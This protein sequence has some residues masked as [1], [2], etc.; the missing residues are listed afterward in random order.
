L[1]RHRRSGV[2]TESQ[3]HERCAACLQSSRERQVELEAVSDTRRA[4][5]L[6][7]VSAVVIEVEQVDVEDARECAIWSYNER[8]ASEAARL[9]D[10]RCQHEAT[11]DS[12][13]EFLDRITVNFLRYD[14]TSYD[15]V[16][17][18]LFRLVGRRQAH[19]LLYE[20]VLGVIAADY[21]ALAAECLR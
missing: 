20:R 10:P 13:P 19:E 12:D 5:G 21:P 8:T 4:K 15:A 17:E 11:V 6:D 1:S 3:D 9:E 7:K 18:N 2:P 14:R 16:G